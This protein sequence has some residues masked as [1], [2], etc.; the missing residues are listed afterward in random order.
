MQVKQ[1]RYSWLRASYE[2]HEERHD[3]IV[4]KELGF[5]WVKSE[6]FGIADCV[7][8]DCTKWPLSWPDFVIDIS[9]QPQW[10]I[11]KPGI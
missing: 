5:E 3:A 7:I 4:M 1:F 6:V 9:E 8:Y 10:T 2:A 11:A